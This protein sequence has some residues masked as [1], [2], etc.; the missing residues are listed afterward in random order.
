MEAIEKTCK[1]SKKIYWDSKEVNIQ[2]T[3]ASRKYK[4]G[5]EVP[6]DYAHAIQLDIQN[7]NN[8]WKD[9]I[10]L[11]IEQIKENQVFKIWESCL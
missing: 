2:T 6:R 1:D 9:A 7:V 8:K 3:K 5:W 11:E 4:H 10:Q